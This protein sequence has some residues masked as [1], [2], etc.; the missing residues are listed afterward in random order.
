M[1]VGG[2]IGAVVVISL[3]LCVAT[4]RGDQSLLKKSFTRSHQGNTPQQR[5]Q[6]MQPPSYI[7]PASASNNTDNAAPPAPAP[8]VRAS[9]QPSAPTLP[10]FPAT[11][12]ATYD[13]SQYANRA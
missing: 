2:T 1:Y 10:D 7:T 13:T 4:R 11:T 8:A 5:N 12:Y 3:V 9:I 6:E